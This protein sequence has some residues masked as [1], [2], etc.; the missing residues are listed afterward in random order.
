MWKF[1]NGRIFLIQDFW[2]FDSSIDTVLTSEFGHDFTIL[3]VAIFHKVDYIEIEPALPTMITQFSTPR[4]LGYQYW[5]D[6]RPLG[7]K[8]GYTLHVCVLGVNFMRW[9]WLWHTHLEF[10]YSLKRTNVARF[11][12]HYHKFCRFSIQF[13]RNITHFNNFCHSFIVSNWGV[14][15]L[16]V[17]LSIFW[18]QTTNFEIF[19]WQVWYFL[20]KTMYFISA[21][22]WQRT[23]NRLQL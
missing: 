12:T 3:K 16:S 10:F 9:F 5:T 17:S 6:Q 22:A 20:G 7:R 14:M 8:G 21:L 1:A 11:T 18:I 13:W 4:G 19:G 23:P 15:K 2:L